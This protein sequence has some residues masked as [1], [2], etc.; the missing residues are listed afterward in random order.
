LANGYSIRSITR[1]LHVSNNTV[2][3]IRDQEWQQVEAG[4]QRI[5]AQWRQVATKAIDHMNDRL[6]Q[7][8]AIPFENSSL[9]PESLPIK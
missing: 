5:A 9:L 7:P 1:A 8:A 4:Q 3:E 2:A 6:N